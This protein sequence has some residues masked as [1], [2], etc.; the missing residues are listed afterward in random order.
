MTKD[1]LDRLR[2][3]V[4]DRQWY[5]VYDNINIAH[6]KFDQRLENADSFD[7]GTVA[8]VVMNKRLDRL[9]RPQGHLSP[10]AQFPMMDLTPDA[11][12]YE[13]LSTVFGLYLVDVLRRHFNHNFRRCS[14]A[15]PSNLNPLPPVTINV[16]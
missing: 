7:N 5:L 3:K 11:S 2:S 13:H 4:M 14:I 15:I 10:Y 12:N 6:Q 8:T 1:A 9:E 16:H